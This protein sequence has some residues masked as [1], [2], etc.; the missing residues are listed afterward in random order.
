MSRS[1]A[2]RRLLGA[3]FAVSLLVIFAGAVSACGSSSGTSAG[4]NTA[5][6]TEAEGKPAP[7]FSGITLNGKTVA[8]D[9]FRGKPLFLIYMTST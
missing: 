1:F 6:T 7:T 5:A 8:L 9:Q 4:G 2:R 3:L